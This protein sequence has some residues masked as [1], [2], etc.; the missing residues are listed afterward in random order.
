[1]SAKRSF[2]HHAFNAKNDAFLAKICLHFG[3]VDKATSS[4]RKQFLSQKSRNFADMEM[5]E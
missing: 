5:G 1:V 4:Q 3:E 2:S